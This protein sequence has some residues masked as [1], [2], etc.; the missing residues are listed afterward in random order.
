MKTGRCDNS[1]LLSHHANACDSVTT[2]IPCKE[3]KRRYDH[4]TG[5]FKCLATKLE[6]KKT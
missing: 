1:G 2:C 3:N 4:K 5:F 6:H